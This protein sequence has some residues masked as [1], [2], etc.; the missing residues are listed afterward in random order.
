MRQQIQGPATLAGPFLLGA[1]N[2]PQREFWTTAHA[3]EVRLT[4][5]L[6][7]TRPDTDPTCTVS[8]L[9]QSGQ[10]MAWGG[11]SVPFGFAS[12]AFSDAVRACMEAFDLSGPDDARKAF[13]RACGEW[14][15]QA[16]DLAQVTFY[17]HPDRLPENP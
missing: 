15:R 2:M 12:W 13:G 6:D 7:D 14:K 10:Q 9:D 8:I 3:T 11:A 1:L 5:R 4:F 16:R 17:V